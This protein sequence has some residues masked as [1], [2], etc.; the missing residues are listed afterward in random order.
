MDQYR[1]DSTPDM[2]ELALY[3][4]LQKE[5]RAGQEL[6]AAIPLIANMNGLK[7]AAH[8]VSKWW[9]GTGGTERHKRAMELRAFA[10]AQVTGQN[11]ADEELAARVIA[12]LV[13]SSNAGYVIKHR[14]SGTRRLEVALQ[15]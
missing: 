13:G 4:W 5:R 1:N 15:V 3:S 2:L 6:I 12:V 9:D 14:H 7:R 8:K 11:D 10:R